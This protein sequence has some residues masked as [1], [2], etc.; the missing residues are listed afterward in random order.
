MTVR[1]PCSEAIGFLL[2][3]EHKAPLGNSCNR[4]PG[5]LMFIL[6]TQRKPFKIKKS[7]WSKGI[8]WPCKLCQRG[9]LRQHHGFLAEWDSRDLTSRRPEV[10]VPFN[11]FF[12][13]W[14]QFGGRRCPWMV[15]MS[16]NPAIQC[17][18]LPSSMPAILYEYWIYSFIS[19][20]Y[21][22]M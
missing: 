7:Y 21:S 17:D 22:I 3:L 11:S 4:K 14:K 6:S 8:E 2:W 9:W 20:D 19:P 10:N 12:I 5:F 18:C 13:W 1:L 15:R 16:W